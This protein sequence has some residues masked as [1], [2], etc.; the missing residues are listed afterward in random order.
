[1]CYIRHLLPILSFNFQS[2]EGRNSTVPAQFIYLSSFVHIC[3]FYLIIDEET[4]VCI[5]S[6]SWKW[7]WITNYKWNWLFIYTC[8]IFSLSP[9]KKWVCKMRIPQCCRGRKGEEVVALWGWI[10]G[11]GIEITRQQ[12]VRNVAFLICVVM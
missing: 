2:S 1:M 10:K 7:K 3:I 9:F 4:S 12:S 8:S 5:F 11:A 6:C